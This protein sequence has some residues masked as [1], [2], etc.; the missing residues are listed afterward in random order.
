VASFNRIIMIGNLTRDPDY[1][2]QSSGQAVCKLSLASN[3]Q[4]RNKQTGAMVQEVC[5]IDVDVW[6]N[7]AENCKQYL[8]KGRP[9]LIEGRLKL[10]TWESEGQ[11]KRRHLI[12]ADRVVFLGFGQQSENA[13]ADSIGEE[14]LVSSATSPVDAKPKKKKVKSENDMLENGS[15]D[16]LFKDEPPFEDDLP[17]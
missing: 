7:Q 3:R 17:F 9:V 15:S 11:V 12:V 1:K 14:S 10:D 16:I 2:I 8:S 13:T 5:Y 4:F 6:G